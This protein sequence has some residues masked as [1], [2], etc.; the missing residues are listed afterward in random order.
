MPPDVGGTGTITTTFGGA[1]SA[2]DAGGRDITFNCVDPSWTKLY[3]GVSSAALPAAGLDA[4]LHGLTYVV[5]SA[6]QMQWDAIS[7]WTNPD[8][9]VTAPNAQV[10]LIATITAG[11]ATFALPPPGAPPS[12]NVL[13]KV[14]DPAGTCSSFTMKIEMFGN[15]G[16]G[17][18]PLNTIK[19][20]PSNRTRSSFTGAFYWVPG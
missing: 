6:T 18:V 9:G 10:R 16:A 5:A 4:S 1:A 15:A 17:F 12:T 8:T 7:P 14:V 11:S 2:G 19:Q 20:S 3:W 13:V